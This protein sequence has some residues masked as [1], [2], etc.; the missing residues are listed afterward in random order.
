M[1]SADKDRSLPP[2]VA[3]R[4]AVVGVCASGKSVLVGG[5]CTLGYD[6]RSC[7]QEHSYVPDMWQRL[8]RPEVLVYL[9]ASLP[10]IHKRRHTTLD[11]GHLAEQRRRLEHARRHCT[12]LVNTDSLTEPQVLA[13]VIAELESLGIRPR[14]AR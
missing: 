13:Q 14:I 6:V 9:D 11:E 5:L 12:V 8:S 2:P 3:G 4:I 10:V 7:A 1:S